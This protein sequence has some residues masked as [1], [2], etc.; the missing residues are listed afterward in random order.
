MRRLGHSYDQIS[1][2]LQVTRAAVAYTCQQGNADPKH[3]LA[4]RR[5]KLM[6]DNAD[7]IAQYVIRAREAGKLLTYNE[8]REVLFAD[9]EDKPSDT[10]IQYVLQ[11]RGLKLRDPPG[12]KKKKP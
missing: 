8:I 1:E 7:N 11:K 2:F 12:K 3:K 6:D 4:G 10:A 5:P 9:T